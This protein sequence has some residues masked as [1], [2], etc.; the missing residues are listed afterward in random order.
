MLF[1][2]STPSLILCRSGRQVRRAFS[3]SISEIIPRL[4]LGEASVAFDKPMMQRFGITH[5][6]CCAEE[7]FPQ[8][9]QDFKY[10]KVPMHNSLGSD[11]FPIFYKSKEFI[12]S[13]M[14]DGNVFV[15]WYV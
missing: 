2:V 14:K 6:L 11:A 15:H 1:A 8:F 7:L 10:L 5:V 13:G 3:S 9:P 4:Y 12:D